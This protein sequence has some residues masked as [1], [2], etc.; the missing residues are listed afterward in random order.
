MNMNVHTS[1]RVNGTNKNV[2]SAF[3]IG[4]VMAFFILI[5]GIFGGIGIAIGKSSEKT[6]AQC[7]VSVEADV[8]NYKYNSDGLSTP[9]YSYIYEGVNYQYSANSYSNHPPYSVGEKAELMIDP[10]SP[11]KAFVPA[12][13][14]N[15]FIATI[16]KCIG[17]GFVG[18][19]VIV[20]IVSLFF[21]HLGKKQAKNDDFSNYEQWQ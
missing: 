1:F 12:D 5:G 8:I 6:K 21:S 18:I 7:T 17:F 19:G 3:V 10:D 11:Q 9:I 20:I 16:F 13:K 2:S 14:T 15:T 4:I